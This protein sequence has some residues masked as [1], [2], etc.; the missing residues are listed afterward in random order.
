M[1][2]MNKNNI[3]NSINALMIIAL[4]SKAVGLVRDIVL[5][6]CFGASY[7]SDAFILSTT[8]PG[9]FCDILIQAITIGFIPIYSKIKYDKG[10]LSANRFTSTFACCL[11]ILC[12]PFFFCFV[13]FPEVIAR[14][15][16]SNRSDVFSLVVLFIRLIAP[17]VFFKICVSVLSAFVESNQNFSLSA[18]IGIPYDLFVIFGIVFSY[19]FSIYWILPVSVVIG[20]IAQF[21][22]LYKKSRNIGFVVYFSYSEFSNEL[23]NVIKLLL[24]MIVIVGVNQFNVVIDRYFASFL[25][26]GSITILDYSNKFVLVIENIVVASIIAVL[27]PRMGEKVAKNDFNG[28]SND[29]REAMNRLVL[30]LIPS[31]F[32]LSLMSKDII[33]FFFGRG[34]FTSSDIQ[35][36]ALCMT[37]YSLGIVFV[38][39][40]AIYTRAIYVLHRVNSVSVISLSTLIF[41]VVLNFLLVKKIGVAGLA[42]STSLSNVFS[43]LCLLIVLKIDLGKYSVISKKCFLYSLFSSFLILI[44]IFIV[45]YLLNKTSSDIII[46]V[47][48]LI[49][50]ITYIIFVIFSEIKCRKELLIC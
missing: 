35:Q 8:I 44:I 13:L 18:S 15:F 25:Q 37:F 27:Y 30:Y 40:R 12:V 2:K 10:T 4:I 49:V 16:T 14:V 46:F 42:L 48:L 47:R 5:T 11:L 34:A 45:N 41:N 50:G 22:L 23:K 21:L 26:E 33:T 43:V 9:A 39:I 29:L 32:I 19:K 20:T 6:T 17:V 3:L 24:P 7:V 1:L 36:T 31:I 38:A 28:L